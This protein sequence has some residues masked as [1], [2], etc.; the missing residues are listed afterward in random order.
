M[1]QADNMRERLIYLAI[2][3]VLVL[4]LF[5]SCHQKCDVMP[6]SSDTITIFKHDT[7]KGESFTTY[8]PKAYKVIVHDTTEIAYNKFDTIV[9]PCESVTTLYEDTLRFNPLGFAVVTDSVDGKILNRSYSFQLIQT[10]EMEKIN[11]IVQA[12]PRNQYFIGAETT[13]PIKYYGIN[14]G[15]KYKNS[16]NLFNL[17]AGFLN[18]SKYLKVGF[19]IR[20]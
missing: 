7:I 12:K 20:L 14:L 9:K 6:I 15:F 8:V 2:I 10:N 19:L 5:K 11:T 3:V 16:N 13:L 4:L 1:L 17:G 18:D